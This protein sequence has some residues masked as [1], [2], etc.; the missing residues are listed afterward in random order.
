M[1]WQFQYAV[2]LKIYDWLEGKQSFDEVLIFADENRA[3]S[4]VS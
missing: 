1:L 4:G 3:Q 2:S